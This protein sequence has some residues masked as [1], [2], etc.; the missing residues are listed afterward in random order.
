MREEDDQRTICSEEY[1]NKK[2]ICCDLLSQRKV[3]LRVGACAPASLYTISTSWRISPSSV[4]L[5]TRRPC[6]ME[7]TPPQA[8]IRMLV[9]IPL[10]CYEL[11]VHL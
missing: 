6:R 11:G 1:K 2:I 8:G 9:V 4:H 10:G 3:R 7:V 5:S